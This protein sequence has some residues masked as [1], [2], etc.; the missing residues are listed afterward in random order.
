MN[1]TRISRLH[2][3]GIFRNFTW[4]SDL[5]DFGQF[6]LIYGWNGSG[7]TTLSRI[8]RNLQLQRPPIEGEAEILANGQALHGSNFHSQSFPN[9]RVFNRDFVADSIFPVGGGNVPP[10][11][12]FGKES[13]AKQKRIE[14]LRIKLQEYSSNLQAARIAAQNAESNLDT[15]CRHQAR[16]IKELLRSSGSNR[17]NNYNK[18]D[19]RNRAHNMLTAGDR[20]HHQLS[21]DQHHHFFGQHRASPKPKIN[22]ITY[23]CLLLAYLFAIADAEYHQA[24]PARIYLTAKKFLWSRQFSQRDYLRGLRFIT[25]LTQV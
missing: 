11:F 21:P 22:H 13:A 8:F 17:Y 2:N 1:I 20:V 15:H 5:P 9:V 16:K 7:K 3:F 6:N 25:A 14:E 19:Y 18:G 12:V 24:I 23:Q 10:I 4:T